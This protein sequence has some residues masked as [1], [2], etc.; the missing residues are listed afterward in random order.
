MATELSNVTSLYLVEISA[1]G[2]FPSTN[3]NKI[4]LSY[5]AIEAIHEVIHQ[6]PVSVTIKS[7]AVSCLVVE[8]IQEEPIAFQETS[9]NTLKTLRKVFFITTFLQRKIKCIQ[10]KV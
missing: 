1:Y 8:P 4:Y 2:Y 5:C 10:Q 3:L 9:E 7:S 6:F